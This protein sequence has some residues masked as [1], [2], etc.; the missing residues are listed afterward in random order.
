MIC[1]R[2]T[3]PRMLDPGQFKLFLNDFFGCE[4]SPISPN[5]RSSVSALVRA[6]DKCKIRLNKA[7]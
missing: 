3:R 1:I 4:S 5:V 7:K 6:L 2:I